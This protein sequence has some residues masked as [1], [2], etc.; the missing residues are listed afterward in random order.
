V[1]DA[2]RIHS[3]NEEEVA[4]NEE[5]VAELAKQAAPDAEDFDEEEVEIPSI[6]KITIDGK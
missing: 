2:D 4:V 5:I 6:N 1:V 3:F